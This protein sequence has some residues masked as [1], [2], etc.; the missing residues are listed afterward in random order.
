MRHTKSGVIHSIAGCYVCHGSEAHWQR[1]N[2]LAC[3]ARH[4][5]A[6]GHPTWCEQAIA[7]FYGEPPTQS[8]GKSDDQ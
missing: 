3:A 6:T 2:A 4:H 5:D 8:E 1:K 7:V